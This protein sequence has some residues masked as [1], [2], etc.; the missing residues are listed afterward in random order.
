M[1]KISQEEQ[2]ENMAKRLIPKKKVGIVHLQVVKE[3]RVLYGMR[4]FTTPLEAVD[5][6][7]PLLSKATGKWFWF[8]P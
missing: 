3:S 5:M 6:V 1:R 4:R 8:Y 7:M 2:L